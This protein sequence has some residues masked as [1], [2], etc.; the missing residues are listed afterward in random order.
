[1]GGTPM[2]GSNRP[3]GVLGMGRARVC[4]GEGDGQ[5][6]RWRRWAP[7]LPRRART[8][9]AT[10]W[11][12]G[13]ALIEHGGRFGLGQRIPWRGM[14]GRRRNGGRPQRRAAGG[15]DPGWCRRL[16]AVGE[17]GA[18]GGR[19]GDEGDDAH[20]AATLGAPGRPDLLPQATAGAGGDVQRAHLTGVQEAARGAHGRQE[21]QCAGPSHLLG[22][23][24]RGVAAEQHRGRAVDRSIPIPVK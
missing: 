20:G 1:V 21:A 16:A 6:Q 3:A 14:A 18:Y 10:V 23:A 24:H 19:V 22:S 13:A 12:P 2:A 11:L 9:R 5:R 7:L 4:R 15:R 8:A 17:D